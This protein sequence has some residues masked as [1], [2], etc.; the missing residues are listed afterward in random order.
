MYWF[1]YVDHNGQEI[2]S[3]KKAYIKDFQVEENPN[4]PGTTIAKADVDFKL[5]INE[6]PSIELRDWLYNDFL[7]TFWEQR[8]KFEKVKEEG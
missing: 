3:P 7:I 6:A 5:R 1:S 2:T 4:K 8:P